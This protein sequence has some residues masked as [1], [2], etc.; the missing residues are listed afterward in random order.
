[1]QPVLS[2]GK[3]ATGAKRGKTCNRCEARENRQPVLS[4]GK[5]AT[6][7]KRGKT[8]NWCQARENMQ[9]ALSAE[10]GIQGRIQVIISF[11]VVVVLLGAILFL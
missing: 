9:P 2:A 7:A 1:M 3:H 10:K 6:G 11:V 5:H 8:G 4:A